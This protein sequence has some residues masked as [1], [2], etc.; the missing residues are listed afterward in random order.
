MSLDTLLAYVVPTGSWKGKSMQE[1][2]NTGET[3][4]KAIVFWNS[5]NAGDDA[6]RTSLKN[7]ASLF[8]QLS[9]S[10]QRSLEAA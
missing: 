5:M 3:G 1:V 7:A 4:Q 9:G 8:L 6:A 10:D 2:L